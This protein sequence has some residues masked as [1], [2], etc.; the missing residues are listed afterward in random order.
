MTL[1]VAALAVVWSLGSA[2]AGTR[3]ASVPARVS[4][5]TGGFVSWTG[6]PPPA[7]TQDMGSISGIVGDGNSGQPLAGICIV[8]YS[9]VGTP[10]WSGSTA[11]NSDGTFSFTPAVA[12][13]Y[14]LAVFRPTTAGNCDSVPLL[15]NPVP[16]WF[17]GV[18]LT[19]GDPHNLTVPG[20]VQDVPTGTSGLTVCMGATA[21]FSDGC[22]IMPTGPGSI[23]GKVITTG[24]QPVPN[25]CVFVL[26]QGLGNVYG[27]VLAGPD[28]SYTVQ[29]LPLN[30]NVVVAFVPPF[31]SDQG[32]CQS[33]GPPP[34]PGPG[35]LQPVFWN[36]VW[37]DLDAFRGSQTDPFTV[38]L[39]FSPTVL[40]A[41]ATGIDGCLTTAPEGTTPRPSCIEAASPLTATPRFTG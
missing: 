7:R 30:L 1:A 16:E 22:Q 24:G 17:Q 33:N 14:D 2:E 3:L 26:P 38:A 37:F 25:A 19:P 35:Q 15:T 10:T 18:A 41:S 31:S 34:K 23:S 12:Q 27:P 28:G 32:P 21:L 5:P 13:D 8:L 20:G 29:G 36:D 39:P 40:Q 4:G 11:T 9:T 6:S